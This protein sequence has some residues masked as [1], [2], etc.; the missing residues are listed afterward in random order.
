MAEDVAEDTLSSAA[1]LGNAM[2]NDP[3]ATIETGAGL[4]LTALSGTGEAGGFLLDATGL[5]AIAGVPLNVVSAAGVATGVGLTAQGMTTLMR[6]AA[7]PDRVNMNSDS[8][9]GGSG[10]SPAARRTTRRRPSRRSPSRPAT[11]ATTAG[12]RRRRRRSTHT[13]NRFTPTGRTTLPLTWTDT[14]WATDGRCSTGAASASAPTAG[15]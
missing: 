7:G 11:W 13:G 6:D 4:L 15:T 14:T 8:S 2:L 1:S 12:Y 3:G 10:D 5:G 9:G